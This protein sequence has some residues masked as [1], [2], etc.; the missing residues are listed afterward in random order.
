M[1][2]GSMDLDREVLLI[3]EIGNNHEGN[4]EDAVALAEAAI[5]SGAQAVKVQVIDPRRLVAASQTERIR[6]LDG[7]RLSMEQFGAVATRVR[8][9]G[10]LFMASAFD[11]DS[12]RAV[13]P[14]L[15]GV[16]IA[17]GDLDFHD[18]VRVGASLD[19]P[20][21]MS[22]GMAT[23]QEVGAAVQAAREGLPSGAVLAERLALLHC[24][25]LYPT[26]PESANLAG[27]ATLREAFGLTVG[28]S[29]HTLGIEVAAMSIALGAR[30]IEKHFTLDKAHSAFRDHAL[31]ADPQDM[32]RLAHLVRHASHVL[33]DGRKDEGVADRESAKAARRSIVAARALPAG[34]TLTLADLE[35]LR[36]G[37]GLSPALAPQV[38]GRKLRLSVP[39][40]GP[41]RL[42]DLE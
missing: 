16:K 38:T 39:A 1:K 21:V 11:V 6:Q 26:P 31:S 42:E 19:L 41:I 10:G 36:P 22:T 7:Y 8:E 37:T 27:M 34:H 12:L 28:Y 25:S 13:A 4:P 30:V 14:L 29:D 2:I 33:G 40:Q 23:L 35:F 9:M 3:A 15:D 20:M 18:L 17:S 5:N 32:K 24:V